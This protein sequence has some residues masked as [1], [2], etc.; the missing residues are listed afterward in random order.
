MI[1]L[2]D[3]SPL[4]GSASA[5]RDSADRAVIEAASGSG[6]MTVSANPTL[7]P[8][9]S[10]QRAA[11]LRIFSLP[12]AQKRMLWRRKYDAARPNIYRGFFPFEPPPNQ[13]AE[14]YDMGPDIAHLAREGTADDPLL[15]ATPFPSKSS[16]PGWR[17]ATSAYY[18]AMERTGQ[19]LMASIAR[20]IGLDDRFFD[21]A[22]VG[23]NS[24]LR[25]LHYPNVDASPVPEG[26]AFVEHQG[27]QRRVIGG[28]H[29]DSGFV[30]LLAQDG[31]EGLQ[32]L[33]ASGEWVDVPPREG[34]LAINFGGLLERWTGG[35]IKATRH[36]VLSPGRARHSIPFFYEPRVDA[37][38]TPLPLQNATTFEP[39][40]YGDHLWQSMLKFPTY[41]GMDDVR[42]PRGV[43]QAA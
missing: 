14:G 8:A 34:T 29:V 26:A 22:F 39:F 43:P 27:Q 40:A 15:E 2:I 10:A 38:I 20:G 25:F 18:K 4:Y 30:T 13:H 36:R 24:T 5:A 31:V 17:A 35:T 28:A 23:G 33:A 3:I 1:P 7:L 11:M 41:R 21:A 32:A 9:T 19:V 12:E 6:F 42:K 16:L 37:V